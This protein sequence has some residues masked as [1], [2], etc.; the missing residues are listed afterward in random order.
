MNWWDT[1]ITLTYGQI[2]IGWVLWV[3]MDVAWD[4]TKRIFGPVCREMSKMFTTRSARE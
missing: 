4:F 3:L 2:V 1:P